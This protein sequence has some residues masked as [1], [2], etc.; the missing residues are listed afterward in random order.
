MQEELKRDIVEWDVT[1]WGKVIDF[2]ENN[3]MDFNEKS[4]LEIGAR[5]G[6]L[7][8]Y[9]ALRGAN[10][11]CSDLNGPTEQAHILHEK[12]GVSDR[13]EY[14]DIDATKIPD[15][16]KEQFDY[17]TFKSVIGGIGSWNDL[18][19]QK[20]AVASCYECL[21]P[22]GRL[23]FADNMVGSPLHCLARHLFVKWGGEM[24]L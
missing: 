3:N 23:I 12:Y 9:Y 17:I 15:R 10:V 5:N 2:I 24:A 4:I 22:G 14:A 16:Y 8:L 1:N 6:G 7:S 18:K 21:K 19:A 13:I 20:S 11:V